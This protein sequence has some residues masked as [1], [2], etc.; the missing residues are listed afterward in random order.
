MKGDGNSSGPCDT[1]IRAK[2]VGACLWREARRATHNWF[3]P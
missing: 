3:R 1:V 2:G